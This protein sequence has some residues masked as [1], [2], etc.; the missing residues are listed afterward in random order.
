[1]C[2]KIKADSSRGRNKQWEEN[3]PVDLTSNLQRI[4]HNLLE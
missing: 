4:L 2:W 3:V 1:M